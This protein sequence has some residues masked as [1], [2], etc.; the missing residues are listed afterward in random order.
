MYADGFGL[1]RIARALNGDPGLAAERRQY[2]A[3]RRVPPPRKGSGSWAPS[4]I[5]A[6][7]RR[8][9]YLGQITWG[10]FKN[11]DKGGRT[12]LRVRQP[13]RQWVS[14]SVP[15]LRILSDTLWAAAEARRR[16][17][18]RAQHQSSTPAPSMAPPAPRAS[19]SL[20]S[21]LAVCA[22][23]GGPIAM[24]GSGKSVPV[25]TGRSGIQRRRR[26]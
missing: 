1:K 2:L 4:C 12:R 8:E 23:C 10:R 13:A 16:Q 24:S 20:L 26:R 25:C 9:R 3:G 11:M 17:Y 6:I 5:N 14:V 21:G 18:D 15:E 19:A 7:L 22:M